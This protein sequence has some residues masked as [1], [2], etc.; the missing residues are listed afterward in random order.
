MVSGATTITATSGAINTSTNLTVTSGFMYILNQALANVL[1]CPV[2]GTGTFG[3][4]NIA[5]TG[6]GLSQP[7][8][9]AFFTPSNGNT[10]A[11]ISNYG[12]TTVFQCLVNTSAGTLSGCVS[13]GG[14]TSP[15]FIS[16]NTVGG[17]TYLYVANQG[18]AQIFQ[19]LV[20]A[21][22]GALSGCANSGATSISVLTTGIVLNAAGGTTYAYVSSFA[23]ASNIFQCTVRAL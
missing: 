19:C 22:T 3:T 7:F 15:A 17:N 13:T 9:L 10:Y 20:N 12:S 23:P 5:A 4:C 14:F 16:I 6:I 11:Y 1:S 21:A 2:T 8:G 18:T